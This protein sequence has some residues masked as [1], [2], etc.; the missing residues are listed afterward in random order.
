[1]TLGAPFRERALDATAAA[2]DGCITA[3]ETELEQLRISNKRLTEALHGCRLQ[4][5]A[6]GGPIAPPT[7]ETTMIREAGIAA[8]VAALHTLLNRDL[9]PGEIARLNVPEGAYGPLVLD[10]REFHWWSAGTLEIVGQGAGAR[11][12]SEG[13]PAAVHVKSRTRNPGPTIL[14][15]R[16]MTIAGRIVVAVPGGASVTIGGPGGATQPQPA[17]PVPL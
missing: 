2:F 15:F 7:I 8:G 3:Y 1:M 4:V 5:T 14:A 6:L 9:A 12:A 17:T 11:I 16:R 10:A 13:S